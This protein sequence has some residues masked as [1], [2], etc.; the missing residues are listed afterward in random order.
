LPALE[1]DATRTLADL[2]Y[3]DLFPAD[4]HE[5]GMKRL[6]WALQSAH[7]RPKEA[8]TTDTLDQRKQRSDRKAA[9]A[10]LQDEWKS[11]TE[12]LSKRLSELNGRALQLLVERPRYWENQLYLEVVKG[13]IDDSQAA[14]RDLDLGITIGE[15]DYLELNRD[16]HLTNEAFGPPGQ[17]GDPDKIVYLADKLGDIYRATIDWTLRWRRVVTHER[18][19]SLLA[20]LAE[21]GTGV[22]ADIEKYVRSFD[23]QVA[24]AINSNPPPGIVLTIQVRLVFHV[25]PGLVDSIETEFASLMRWLD[26]QSE[27]TEPSPASDRAGVT[28]T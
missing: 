2:E 22:L 16:E 12:K 17:A 18:L 23:Q 21:F 11:R 15:R 5:D 1:I 20:L 14:K 27:A 8:T 9:T 7:L 10:V 25:R 4:R 3:V 6:L 13:A 24:F 26:E 28:T 19:Q